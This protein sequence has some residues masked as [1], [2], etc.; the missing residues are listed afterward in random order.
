V[1]LRKWGEDPASVPPNMPDESVASKFKEAF[2]VPSASALKKKKESM[3]ALFPLHGKR[4]A[5]TADRL[6][7]NSSP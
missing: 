4:W 7:H 3:R 2:A 6:S 5:R 1:L